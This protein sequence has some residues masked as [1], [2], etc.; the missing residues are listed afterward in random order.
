MRRSQSV[1]VLA[2]FLFFTG[3][4]L[5]AQTETKLKIE[6]PPPDL[7]K[8]VAKQFGPDFSIV[9]SPPTAKIQAST[10]MGDEVTQ[11][12]S[13][14][15]GDFDGDGVED[16]VIIARNKNANLGA[17][18]YGYKVLDVYNDHFGYGNPKVTA[19]FNQDDPLHNMIL[20]VIHGTGKEGW[21]N[22]KPKA[23]FVLINVPFES[24]DLTKS[25]LKKKIVDALRVNES[26]G[27]AS[28]VYWD[29]KKYKYTPG[30]GSL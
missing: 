26:D 22:P 13:L 28:L 12:S 10:G 8:I 17:D 11:W 16:A 19:A 6:P 15:T 7:A 21:R 24:V 3:A 29:G 1:L 4:V 2:A 23:K 20:L 25:K 18:A 27:V 9:T 30:G 14:L 5:L